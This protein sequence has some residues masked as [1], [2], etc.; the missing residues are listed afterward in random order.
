MCSCGQLN[1]EEKFIAMMDA[2]WQRGIEKNPLYASS[3]GILNNNDKWPTYSLEQ[4][5]LDNLHNKKILDQLNN[6]DVNSFQNPDNLLNFEL[7]KKQYIDSIEAHK[8]KNFLIPFSHRGGIQLQHE[9]A[10]TLPL[11]NISHYEDWIARLDTIDI[12]INNHISIARQGIK[13]GIMPPRILMDRVLDQIEAQAFVKPNL[14]PFFKAFEEMHES[15][16]DSDKAIIRT[17][18]LQVIEKKVIPAYIQFYN[19]FKNEYLVNCRETIGINDIP[20]GSK[21]YEFLAKK[22]TTTNLTP[23]EIHNIGLSEVN[24]IKSEMMK[25]IDEVDWQGTFREFLEYLRTDPRFYFDNADDLL[26]EY[27]ATAKRIDPE[28]VNLFSD[29]P[30]APYGIRPIPMESAPD[31]TTAYYQRPAADGSR[32]GYYY[33]N[34]YRP[35][36]RPKYEIEVLTVHEAMPGHHLQIAINMELDLPNFRKYGGLTAFVEG[37]GLYSEALGYDLGLYKDPYSKFGQLTYEMWR[38]IRLV[39]D[40][41]MHYKNWSRQDSINFFLENSAK[42]KQDIINEVDRYINWPGQALAYKIG[43]MK[44]LELRERSEEIL[45]DSFDIKEFHNEVLKRGALPLSKLEFYIDE[46][47]A[48]KKLGTS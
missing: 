31:T 39:V 44:I 3:M 8:Y 23:D 42:S 21:Y 30:S 11:R 47:I 10:E 26:T 45:G 17:K 5:E 19:F 28:L 33:V 40:T 25:V 37:W 15:I 1:D 38:A 43:Q 32:A 24:R 20:N 41:G 29:L 7:F 35:E 12:Y 16:S 2:E 9:S 34:L 46:W 6:F 14:S 48:L 27:L 36:V 13:E 22:Y 18:A 4:I